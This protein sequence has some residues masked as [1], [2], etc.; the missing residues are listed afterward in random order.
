MAYDEDLARRIREHLADELELD[1]KRMFGGLAFLIRGHLTVAAGRG[2]AMLAR[3]D[4]DDEA[5]TLA[6]TGVE[7]MS[8]NQNR[9][10]GWVR[11]D[12]AQLADDED[13]HRWIDTCLDFVAMLPPK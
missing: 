8:P 11:V 7:P 12:A 2:G 10:T 3:T 1:E 13:L 9:M 6:L 5:A 4:P